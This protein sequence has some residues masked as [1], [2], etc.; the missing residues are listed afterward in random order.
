MNEKR[1]FIVFILIVG[2]LLGGAATV[3]YI[4]D[5]GGEFTKNIYE[6]GVA[7]ILL[8]GHNVG[9]VE[10]YD[11]RLLQKDLIKNDPRRIDLI[12]LG[13]SRSMQIS[14]STSIDQVSQGQILFNHA[15]SGASIEDDIALLDLYLEKGSIPQTVIIGVDPWILNANNQQ[16]RWISLRDEYQHGVAKIFSTPVPPEHNPDNISSSDIDPGIG[17]YISTDINRYSSLI[18]RPIIIK[19]IIG[20]L[21][22]QNQTPYFQTDLEESDVAIKIKDG[23]L[24]YPANFRD[25]TVEQIDKDASD[26]ANSDPIYSLGGFTQI[27]EKSKFLFESTIR[28][29][30]S[31][32]TT[33][34]MFLPPYNPIVYNKM[35]SD[36]KYS[37][38]KEVESYIKEF[39][40]IENITIVGSYDPNCLNLTSMDF[41]DGMHP[42]REGIDKI[43]AAGGH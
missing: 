6:E 43:F 11:E 31:R 41:Y 21:N 13:S 9:N 32:N 26:Y 39:A 33:I 28:Y 7:H 19:S 5:P 17:F 22:N 27:D 15:V 14:N 20:L 3:S 23:S 16:G 38:V 30:K 42:R 18:S 36:P 40:S 2:V 37:N 10:N 34:I 8:S 24:S 4:E 29:L 35:T 25:R 1:I 12:V